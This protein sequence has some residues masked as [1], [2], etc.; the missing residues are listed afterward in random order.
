MRVCKSEGDSPVYVKMAKSIL[1][2][3]IPGIVWRELN[4]ADDNGLVRAL[5]GGLVEVLSGRAGVLGG[6][7]CGKGVHFGSE[8]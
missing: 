3:P 1:L 5:T 8:K 2:A 7:F 4:V 6:L